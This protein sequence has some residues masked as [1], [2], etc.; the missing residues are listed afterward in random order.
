MTSKK[1]L[2]IA[3][4]FAGL[5]CSTLYRVVRYHD[6]D[7]ATANE[8]QERESATLA[9]L[10]VLKDR[11]QTVD[12][13]ATL[14]PPRRLNV[15]KDFTTENNSSRVTTPAPHSKIKHA[16][17]S[18]TPVKICVCALTRSKPTWKTL[19]DSRVMK[20]V[21][22]STHHTTAMEW[23]KFEVQILLGADA[24]DAFWQRHADALKRQ[25]VDKYELDVTFKFYQKRANFLPF[26]DLMRD[27][28]HTGSEY[29]VRINDDTE[30]TSQGWI[31]LGVDMLK[32]FQ[33]ANV[34]VVGPTCVQGNTKILTHDMVHRTHLDIF[35]TYYPPIFH[36]WYLD[37]W[38]SRVYGPDR[39]KK[40]QG[41]TVVHHVEQQG[42][43]Y[44][45]VMSDVQ[46][47]QREVDA[48]GEVIQSYLAAVQNK[49]DVKV[50]HPKQ[51][52]AYSLYGKNPRYTDGAI[53]NAK[54]YHTIYPGWQ[55]RVY[56]DD[57]VSRKIL[58]KLEGYGVQLRD[59]SKS[60]MNAMS[61]RFTVSDK[62]ARF[63]AR[64]IDSRL[65]MREKLA[66]DAWVASGKKFHV[67]RDH[68]S[69]SSYALSGGM[70]CASDAGMREIQHVLKG[71]PSGN[72]YLQ[73]MN[74]LNA[75]VWPIAQRSVLQHDSFSCDKFGGGL[76]FPTPRVGWE[77]VGSVYINGKMRAIDTEILSR[78]IPP[79]KC[80]LQTYT[81]G[82]TQ[83][84][85]TS[86]I[87]VWSND[88]HI[89][90]IANVKKILEPMDVN[91]ID[92]SLSA[93]CDLTKTCATDLK[94][95]TRINGI[96]PDSNIRSQFYRAYK[97]DIDFHTVDVVM[98][99]HPSAMCELFMPFNKRI[100]VIATTRYEMGREDTISWTLWNKNLEKIASDPKNL[101]AA[102]NA[103]DA[104]YIEYF[105]GIRPT[106]LPSWI[107]MQ[108]KY[109]GTHRDILVAPIHSPGASFIWKSLYKIS[110]RFQDVKVKYGHYSFPQLCENTAIL[111]FPYQTSVMSLFEQYGMGI[112]IIVPTPEFL[113]S[114]H[115]KFDLVT[116]RT[117][118]RVRHGKRPFK[119]AIKGVLDIP[120]PNNDVSK[121]DF[122]YWIQLSDFYQWPYIVLFD[123]WKDLE[124]K[125]Q[126]SV[127]SKISHNM[128]TYH[129][130]VL[131]NTTTLWKSLLYQVDIDMSHRQNPQQ[132][133]I[134]YSKQ[135][136]YPVLSKKQAL[137]LTSHPRSA[138]SFLIIILT[139]QRY[140]SLHRLLISINE[141]NYDNHSV[142]LK[143]I[144]DFDSS[145]NHNKTIQVAEKFNFDHGTK[146]ILINAERKG[147]Q[148]SWFHAWDPL[149]DD[150]RAVIIEDDMEMSPFWF[151]WLQK[152]WRTYSNRLDL[153][154]ISLQR[155][156][157]RASDG[158]SVIK[159]ID[160]PFLYKIPGSFGFSPNARFWKPF[161]RWVRTVNLKTTDIDVPGTVTTSWIPEER[162]KAWSIFYIWWC[163]KHQLYTL[164]VHSPNGA[165]I[166]HWA[167][168]GV[169]ASGRPSRNDNLLFRSEKIL[170]MF[171]QKLLHYDW[172]FEIEIQS[173]PP[174]LI[175]ENSHKQNTKWSGSVDERVQNY[176]DTQ[177]L[178]AVIVQAPPRNKGFPGY[179][180][181][182][183]GKRLCLF[184]HMIHSVD[185]HL[186]Q[187]LGTSYPIYVIVSSDPESD[188]IGDD[189][190]Y[191]KE[192]RDLIRSWAPHSNVFFLDIPM[193]T[194]EALSPGTDK[195]QISRWVNGKDG[196]IGGRPLGYRSMCRLWSGRL[197][198]MHFLDNFEFYMR[199]DDDSFFTR[200]LHED[201]FHIA[202]HA[203]L[204]YL[205]IRK[206]DDAW[207]IQPL[208]K[209]AA[210]HGTFKGDGSSPYT[211]FHLARV[212][213]FRSDKFQ[214]FWADLE[215][216]HIFFKSRVGDAL[217]HNVMLEL[218]IPTNRIKTMPKMPYAHNSNDYAG[219]PPKHWHR[220]CPLLSPRPRHET[221]CKNSSKKLN[222]MMTEK[223][224]ELLS[225]YIT[226][227]TRYFEWGSGGSTDTYGRLTDG[228]VVSIENFKPWCDKVAN[229]PF[230]RCR[231][232][233]KSL[234]YKCIIPHATGP[235]GYPED[236]NR[237]G[238]F[239]EYL[240]A[241]AAHPNFDVVLVDGRWRVA[242]A[243]ISLDYI[244]DSTVV[245][246][247][248]VSDTPSREVYKTV[249]K[250]YDVIAQVDTLVA[251]RRKKDVPRPSKQELRWW[252]MKPEC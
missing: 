98:C 140:W 38:I 243:M 247:H 141:A 142:H 29:L 126:T 147:L 35:K 59:M 41:W 112:P 205:Y 172:N 221:Q 144:V 125:I 165:L 170:E 66:V 191:S 136:G 184:L 226:L 207:G 104:K 21:I 202:K 130:A 67:M 88:F 242:C 159:N 105:T 7:N 252:E 95:L 187:A 17:P 16:P 219:Y 201:P 223:E 99:F 22:E 122:L 190:I 56:H 200:D 158:K 51:I 151:V 129:N 118:Y 197:Q 3:I 2:A 1:I 171:P 208:K 138:D 70:W 75:K 55:M 222:A 68:P 240:N 163:W 123:S 167:E 161:L 192:D 76:P 127:W 108:D 218:F 124:E 89:S 23:D 42:Q 85:G 9:M 176:S 15:D 34:G 62:A 199:L 203:G 58:Q 183:W 116:E 54:L 177:M 111:Y 19:D 8:K 250:W 69:H 107:S 210:A 47:L 40:I 173:R 162:N 198:M 77:H 236:E 234:H 106:L 20:N 52:I 11:K 246:M 97:E 133:G 110:N 60:N 44:K 82:N 179:T 117:W 145:R 211:N 100:F 195:E 241:I 189:A 180:L 231:E 148:Y 135:Q 61:W 196:G 217:L 194:G 83:K 182:S 156:R 80:S 57:S 143:I 109:K 10:N 86:K 251:M 49:P 245:F 63:C 24:D 45:E 157:L 248:D 229:L 132:E 233:N 37:D 102:N 188:P 178:G 31:S 168:P 206:S 78:T 249:Y 79:T 244:K 153:G 146:T 220:E 230:V 237:N 239:A 93:H 103:Y 224:Q 13:A 26:N 212:S 48:G 120:D 213:I 72:D 18:S 160:E 155:Q 32:N 96:S 90:T 128:L 5:C 87:T 215:A 134:L 91:F 71:I 94:V 113:W 232:K 30:F 149:A 150:E 36:N 53:A 39:T 12:V 81:N 73:D 174:S 228:T 164:Y 131:K 114:L 139:Q 166:G 119:S 115:N 209:V 225:S 4:I 33:P 121:T 204:D 28:Y 185:K 25:A 227:T 193:Y 92:K 175:L 27:G 101:I 50:E 181:G 214:K 64:D 65:S 74:W 6:M 186:N 169:H 46:S 235:F 152:A 14:S 216:Q 84:N 238:D 43:R 137:T 154:G